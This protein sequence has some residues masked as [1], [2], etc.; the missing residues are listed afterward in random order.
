M[1]SAFDLAEAQDEF[2]I[3]RKNLRSAT[4]KLRNAE[5]AFDEAKERMARAD[6]GLTMAVRGVREG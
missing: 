3:A 4:T 5:Q 2:E 1:S 6:E